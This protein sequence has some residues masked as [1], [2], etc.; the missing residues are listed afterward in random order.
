MAKTGTQIQTWANTLTDGGAIS[1]ANALIWINEFLT[2]KLGIYA[3]VLATDDQLTAAENTWI[4]LPAA[5]ED[6][7]KVEKFAGTTATGESID[8][9]SW[10]TFNGKIRYKDSGVYRNHYIALPTEL[11]ALT[12][13]VA[14]D[15]CF[16]LAC[17]TWLA[18]R[19]L[20]NSDE[21]Y[22]V[23]NTIGTKREQE[24][25]KE[26]ERSVNYRKRK[27]RRGRMRTEKINYGFRLER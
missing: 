8:Y 18:Y 9:T 7:F 26:L 17:A 11:T 24:F 25:Y 2:Q 16:Y 19:Y 3:Y 20:T 6:M 10:E 12:S 23:S 14:V 15:Q 1:D 21:D 5:C 4:S 22:A 27:L 13:N